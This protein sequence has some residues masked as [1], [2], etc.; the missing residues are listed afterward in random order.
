MPS[1]RELLDDVRVQLG[2]AL[3]SILVAT[4]LA[5]RFS[6][7]SPSLLIATFGVL[8]TVTIAL[9]Q[10]NRSDPVGPGDLEATME[11]LLDESR[12]QVGQPELSVLS[13]TADEHR[14]AV[15]DTV[16]EADGEVPL[17]TLVPA[18]A[19]EIENV[20]RESVTDE[21]VAETHTE[22]YTLHLD[23]LDDAGYIAFSR[24]R[25]T[26]RITPEGAMVA[27]YVDDGTSGSDSGH[28]ATDDDTDPPGVDVDVAFNVLRNARRR[29][30]LTK[31][32]QE[33]KAV[34]LQTLVTQV[35]AAERELHPKDVDVDSDDRKRVYVSLYQTHLP[36]LVD[37]GFLE[38]ADVDET[39]V[40][41]TELGDRLAAFAADVASRDHRD[42]LSEE[43]K[44]DLL[45]NR[46][47]R[48]VIR[49]LN[50]VESA[51]TLDDLAASVAAA[52]NDTSTA[53]LSSDQRKRVYVS[54]Y[55]A[56]LPKLADVG[57]VEYDRESGTVHATDWLEPLR[58]I[59]GLFGTHFEYEEQSLPRDG[60][61]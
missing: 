22:L 59:T 36:K 42:H 14:Q 18:V 15:I 54:L 7:L 19:A 57:V 60:N 47:R 21:M 32:R 56:H 39:T 8:G 2:V 52:E 5:A 35:A 26:V 58:E 29:E 23:R 12:Q 38:Y 4:F 9:L 41:T 61:P 30:V 10:W 55:Q 6:E 20:P 37:A 40:R 13:V 50:E 33:S 48:L 28:P 27:E 34:D 51:T 31:L 1:R 24:D 11:R 43:T 44:F 17:T 3:P 16:L 53:A 45:S 49:Y 25:G 46:R